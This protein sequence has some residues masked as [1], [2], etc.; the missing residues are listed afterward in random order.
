MKKLLTVSLLMLLVTW[1]KAQN[2]PIISPVSAHKVKISA[3]YQIQLNDARNQAYLLPQQELG[4]WLIAG[5][6]AKKITPY[7][8]A[9]A[10]PKHTVRTM[11]PG[12]FRQRLKYYDSAVG[13]SVEVSPAD[14]HL[15]ELQL[16]IDT[17]ESRS[18]L[19]EKIEYL[20]IFY[21][22]PIQNKSL[23]MATFEYTQV[24]KYLKRRFRKSLRAHYFEALE[25]V[26]Y[27]A[28][29]KRQ[30]I[31][32]HEA[33]ERH[34]YAGKLMYSNAGPGSSQRVALPLNHLM[35]AQ[36]YGKRVP[37]FNPDT[38]LRLKPYFMPVGKR[39]VR[40]TLWQALDLRQAPNKAYNQGAYSLSA[41]LIKGIR[42]KKIQAYYH[43]SAPFIRRKA[44][45]MQVKDFEQHLT[46]IQEND[47]LKVNIDSLYL[48]GMHG[49]YTQY[50]RKN[51]VKRQVQ[52]LTLMIPQ[53]ATTEAAFGNLR[54]ANVPY[55]QV[56]RYLRKLQRKQ[57]TAY[58]WVNNFIKRKYHTT[59]V[60]FSHPQNDYLK[61]ILRLKFPQLSLEEI[62]QKSLQ[63]GLEVGKL[64]NIK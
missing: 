13:D 46:Y 9:R 32:M 44:N 2:T 40:T 62:E 43:T 45:K 35:Y 36:V 61:N 27:P 28:L 31:G 56:V 1:A 58:A 54:V 22:N 25:A 38:A 33:L 52:V 21:L 49:F 16:M 19:D 30:L 26:W 29:K 48:V 14:M 60:R 47:T 39:K 53:G 64:L 42:A 7:Y 57:P 20:S 4:R 17:D 3:H 5:V 12:A 6:L 15:V 10:T 41:A 63:F 59:L 11:T 51:K 50:T 18:K 23:P 55:K 24:R 34:W 8:Y 37:Q